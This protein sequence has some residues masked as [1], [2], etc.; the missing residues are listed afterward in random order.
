[1]TSPSAPRLTSLESPQVR[2][3]LLR[4]FALPQMRFP[5]RSIF[6]SDASGLP[7]KLSGLWFYD[8]GW[9]CL[10]VAGSRL[11]DGLSLDLFPSPLSPLL[12]PPW[13]PQECWPEA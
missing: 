1:M 7:S 3:A 4:G 6:F 8:L 9:D 12:F 13:M 2:E 10:G 5:R 11:P